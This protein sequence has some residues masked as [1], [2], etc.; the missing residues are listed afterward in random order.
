MKEDARAWRREGEKG[1]GGK[2]RKRTRSVHDPCGRF[3]GSQFYT[4]PANAPKATGE[5]NNLREITDARG[6][7]RKDASEE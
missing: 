6:P 7:A 5:G 3:M 2:G 4:P 1:G